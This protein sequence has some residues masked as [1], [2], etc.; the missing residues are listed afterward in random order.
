[1]KAPPLVDLE[2][3]VL[4][5]FAAIVAG[6]AAYLTYA[7]GASLHYSYLVGGG[8]GGAALLWA[9]SVIKPPKAG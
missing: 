7:S 5:L 1:M 8:A 2:V 9:R 4:L 3:F 6:L